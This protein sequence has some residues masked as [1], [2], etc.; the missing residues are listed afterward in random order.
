LTSDN[1]PSQDSDLA[2][3]SPEATRTYFESILAAVPDAMI[4]INQT[5]LISE[6]SRAAQ[7][8]FGYSQS[9]VLGKNVSILMTD[10]DNSRH[11]GYINRYLE[12]HEPQIIG[13]GRVVMAKKAD[14]TEFP[15][16]LKIGEATI[17]DRHIFTGFIR[18]L[19]GQQQ[20]EARM[21]EMQSEL[22]HF[23]RLSAVGTMASAL[24]HELNQPLTAVA[25]YLEASRDL[26]STPDDAT[27]AM[28][29]EALTEAS[30]QSVRAGQ[31]VRKL[32]DF[33]TRGEITT[34]AVELEQLLEDAVSLALVSGDG[35]G[36]KIDI[37]IDPSLSRV[38]AEPIQI[39]QVM[40]NLLRNSFE[41]MEPQKNARLRVTATPEPEGFATIQI[42][43]NGPGLDPEI[44]EQLFRPFTSTKGTG[45]GL[46]LS[47]CQTIIEAHGG[48][49][50]AVPLP[51]SGCSF[52]FTLPLRNPQSDT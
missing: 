14:G 11:D 1:S 16:N 22:V 17:G 5:G 35:K 46:G 41:A 51:E 20:A 47:I 10:A 32:R 2:V 25:N 45:M 52:Q 42:A 7:K 19:S 39:Q 43:D 21:R 6:F 30:Q 37:E 3:L 4:V 27:I 9:D 36:V 23:S 26:L 40:V 49:I 29:Q 24:A 8:M 50:S 13:V 12:T 28:V 34:R 44:A 31:I 33:V 48:K 18:D 15:V 38:Q